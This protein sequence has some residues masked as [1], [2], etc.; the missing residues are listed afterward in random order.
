LMLGMIC[1]CFI[2][3]FRLQQFL[4]TCNFYII[5]IIMDGMYAEERKQ[6]NWQNT[7]KR[8]SKNRGNN[9]KNYRTEA[10]DWVEHWAKIIKEDQ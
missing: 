5:E 6:A 4:A 3:A 2:H 8:W 1:L 10:Y 7:V 9:R